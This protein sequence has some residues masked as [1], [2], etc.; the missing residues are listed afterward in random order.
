MQWLHG[1]SLKGRG[2]YQLKAI[3][4]KMSGVVGSEHQAVFQCS[5]ADKRGSK[6]DI[7]PLLSLSEDETARSSRNSRIWRQHI[8]AIYQRFCLVNLFWVCTSC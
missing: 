3:E 6:I 8:Q 7:A 5:R 1:L 4:L 2:L